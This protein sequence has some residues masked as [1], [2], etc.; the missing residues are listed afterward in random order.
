MGLDPDSFFSG[1]IV[2]D[3]GCGTGEETLFLAS[4]R[5]E[6][7][8]G[9]DTSEG[10][11]E[12]AREAARVEGI[13]NVE[14]RKHS[15]LDESIFTDREF[16]YVSSLGCIHHTP[17]T[18]RAFD[19]L[20]RLVKPGGYLNTFIYNTFGHM[21]YNEECN[22]LDRWAG[23]DVEARVSLARKLFDWR[24]DKTFRREGVEASYDA[25]MYDKYGVLFR[26][27]ITLKTLLKWYS[28]Q[29]FIHHGS[30][31]MYLHDMVDAF[32]AREDD[33]NWKNGPKAAVASF[34]QFLPC[35]NRRREWS[36][37]RRFAMQTLLLMIGLHDYGSSFRV[38][39]QKAGH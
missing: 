37:Y 24:Q 13:R 27:A 38:V 34:L 25:R 23:D 33:A 8:I 19:N 20:C 16:D 31:P 11:L 21:L 29:D 36:T 17:S 10:S 14:F 15:V 7:V 18:R 9:I 28:E 30:F 4:L 35:S 32:K 6:Q 12:Y 26:D 2:L 5:P 22:I 1:K 39:C 3:V